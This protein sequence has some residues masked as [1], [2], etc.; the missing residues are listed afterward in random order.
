MAT[1]KR[2][3]LSRQRILQA[4]LHVL[5]REGLDAISMR[6]VGEE[7]GVEAMSLYRH[8]EN[9]AAIL[10]GLFEAILAELPPAKRAKSW[11]VFLRDRAMALRGV[12]VAHPEALPI[13]A[14][15]PAVTPVSLAYVEDVLGVLRNEGFSA[16][17]ALSTMQVLMAFVVGHTL[18]THASRKSEDASRPLYDQLD[19][20]A[21]PRVRE[22]A[23]VLAKH[24]V[25]KE[26]VF[27]LEAMVRGIEA[28][29]EGD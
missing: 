13:F 12:L 10:D 2:E 16:N 11:S 24:D 5:D 25:E 8:V 6:R 1:K 27:G 28:R 29:R 7:L 9:K 3:P 18:S 17:D 22:A 23:R 15:R 20:A 14:T 4:A 26:F 19:E 21:F